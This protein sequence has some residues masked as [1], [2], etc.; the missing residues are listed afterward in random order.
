MNEDTKQDIPKVPKFS[1]ARNFAVIYL[2]PKLRAF[3]QK[4]AYGIADSEDPDQAAPLGA[5]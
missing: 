1:D 4:G 2:R 3:H 5:D